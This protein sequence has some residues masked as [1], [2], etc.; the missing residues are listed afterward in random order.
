M[1]AAQV[2]L[3]LQIGRPGSLQPSSSKASSSCAPRSHSTHRLA[4][5]CLRSS[6]A[7]QSSSL[8]HSPQRAAAPSPRQRPP[9]GQ[10]R[11]EPSSHSQRCPSP[12]FGAPG[13]VQGWPQAVHSRALDVSTQLGA[14]P[15]LRSQHS[16]PAPQPACVVRS[17]LEPASSA[18]EL[19]PPSRGAA[20]SWRAAPSRPPSFRGPASAS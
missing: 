15:S 4:T 7:R 17:Q 6:C 14:V 11:P 16:C 5:H 10:P 18:V 20:P 2:L 13:S 8:T 3:S 12:Q 9:F 19:S 1:H